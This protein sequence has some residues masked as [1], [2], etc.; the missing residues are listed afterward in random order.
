MPDH[1][2]TARIDD[3]APV[4]R[5][6]ADEVERLGRIPDEIGKQLKATGVVRLLQPRRWGGYEEDPRLFFRSVM[7]IAA[8]CGASGWVSGIVGVHP[9]ELAM[10]DPRAQ[11]EVWADDPDTWV[12]ST[13]MP[14]GRAVAVDGGYRFSGRWSYSSGCDIADWILLG[15]LVA[16]GDGT[17]V[18]PVQYVHFLLP[19][20]DYT[21][22]EGTWDVVGL[23]GTGSKDVVVDD[24]FVPAYRTVSDQSLHDGTAPGATEDRSTLYRMPWSSIFPNAIT[25]AAIGIAEGALAAALDYQRDRVSM[26]AGRIV[27][28][29]YTMTVVGQA[30]SE[31]HAS[32]A[33]L[34][35]NLGE[36][37]DLLRAGDPVT[38][39]LRA[40]GRSAQVRNSWRVTRAVDELF[41]HSGGGSLR[42]GAPL[43][44][45][46]RDSHAALHHIINTPDASFQSYAGVAMG[47]DPRETIV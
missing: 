8:Q 21:I 1:E 3:L 36:M 42:R 43:Q 12:C 4:L 11:E 2:V 9:W 5:D 20:V 17:L 6:G 47:F 22:V 35:G 10:Y 32:R 14:T 18:Q 31:I 38:M 16:N 15:G 44:R 13:Y 25:A 30:A 40:R 41:D 7:E 39:E 26:S 29:P 28:A 19:H 46:W 45:F 24:A 34:L 33:S 37:W 27:E 23:C